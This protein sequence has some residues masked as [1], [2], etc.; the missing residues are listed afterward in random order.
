LFD[1]AGIVRDVGNA[2]G[3]DLALGFYCKLRDVTSYL[4]GACCRVRRRL[5]FRPA[6]IAR[7]A[8]PK[9]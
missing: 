4:G 7:E 8:A 6:Y 3:Q 1:R 5:H 2:A 9:D